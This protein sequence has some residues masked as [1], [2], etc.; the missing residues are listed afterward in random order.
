MLLK[1]LVKLLQRL[2]TCTHRTLLERSQTSK[3]GS[4][5]LGSLLR[6]KLTV[7]PILYL[8]VGVRREHKCG[9]N[10]LNDRVDLTWVEYLA[11]DKELFF[12]STQSK[13]IS[14]WQ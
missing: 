7:G 10:C 6:F 11:I 14:G 13:T 9:H 4:Y 1:I 12:V 2:L 8:E 5:A 3:F